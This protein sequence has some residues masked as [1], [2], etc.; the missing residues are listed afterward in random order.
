[1]EASRVPSSL[2]RTRPARPCPLTVLNAPATT[3]LPLLTSNPVTKLSAPSPTALRKVCSA[4]PLVSRAN[5]LRPA[6]PTLVKSPP[7]SSSPLPARAKARTAPLTAVGGTKPVSS[8]PL[9]RKRRAT[10]L[11]EVPLRLLKSP[12]T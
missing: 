11:R 4:P 8:A 2:R 12:A 6:P 1:M 9:A 5:R 7:M 3:I 10:L